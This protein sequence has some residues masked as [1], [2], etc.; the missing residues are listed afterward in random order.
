MRYFSQSIFRTINRR[1][2]AKPFKIFQNHPYGCI[3]YS[4]KR[5]ETKQ[6]V[7]DETS[8]VYVTCEITGVIARPITE[9]L[10]PQNVSHP[11]P[12]NY[13]EYF[14]NDKP[15]DVVFTRDHPQA[16][17]CTT[18]D[19]AFPRRM[20]MV[21]Y[22]LAF[23]H[24]ERWEYPVKDDNG[25]IVGKKVT[26]KKMTNGYYCLRTECVVKRHP[27]FWKGLSRIRDEIAIELRPVL[28]SSAGCQ[29]IVWSSVGMNF[30]RSRLRVTLQRNN[31][32]II[33]VFCYLMVLV[34]TMCNLIKRLICATFL[35]TPAS[36]VHE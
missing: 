25:K 20:P 16:S 19:V 30:N 13:T 9:E 6:L 36:D 24:N 17:Q 1:L 2:L 7:I 8:T 26:K 4:T 28:I 32:F 15:F 35:S 14:H 18:C 11:K 3:W 22:D 12:P 21:P 23:V 34:I 10:D 31:E 33:T 27:Y 5:N 29:C